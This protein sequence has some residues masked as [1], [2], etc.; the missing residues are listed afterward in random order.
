M[1]FEKEKSPEAL[2]GLSGLD[3]DKQPGEAV[4]DSDYNTKRGRGKS[5]NE[6]PLGNTTVNVTTH[7]KTSN[8]FKKWKLLRQVQEILEGSNYRVLDC[9]KRIGQVQVLKGSDGCYIGGIVSCGSVWLCPVCNRRI[10][11]ER[12]E[13]IRQASR[14]GRSMVM[15][16]LT[17]Q[18]HK[19]DSLE[20]VL[21]ALK[22]AARGMKTGG[23]WTRFKRDYNLVA[24]VTSYEITYGQNGWHPH[25]HMLLFF[26]IFPDM[27]DLW[28]KLVWRWVSVVEKTGRYASKYHALDV[29]E[30]EAEGAADYMTK[31]R[32]G[33]SYELTGQSSKGRTFWDLVNQEKRDLVREYASATFG[34]KS[35][36]WSHHAK[37]ILG[38]EDVE[39]TDDVPDVIADIP[40]V[41]WEKIRQ[42][43]LQ[44][45]T[46]ELAEVNQ[47]ALQQFFDLVWENARAVGA[48]EVREAENDVR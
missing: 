41:V 25:V 24:Y 4:C 34:L 27:D 2:G 21:N 3:G 13:M 18:H 10:A 12:G 37:E 17:L 46:L 16:T 15:L 19:G 31:W 5:E 14:S 44:G 7:S 32:G 36:T 8:K 11:A 1:R 45:Y 26:D 33:V 30:A 47:D 23:W 6:L 48:D 42:H 20:D 39:K 35:M 28:E 40:N 38:T 43:A 29:Q 22:E 9:Q